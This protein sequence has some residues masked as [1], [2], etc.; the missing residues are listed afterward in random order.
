MKS[1]V[2]EG[3]GSQQTLRNSQDNKIPIYDSLE[4]VTADLANL[5]VGQIVATKDTGDE[6]VQPVN[7]VEE[8]NLHAVSSNAVY[9]YSNPQT[10]IIESTTKRTVSLTAGSVAWY[11]SGLALPTIPANKRLIR[12]IPYTSAVSTVA[13]FSAHYKDNQNNYI[14]CIVVVSDNTTN[15]D[16]WWAAEVADK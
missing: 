16:I 3:T 14:P 12:Y 1:Y 2:T 13:V 9:E 8:G 10:T 11:A 5:K 6:L 7:V 4:D 15:C